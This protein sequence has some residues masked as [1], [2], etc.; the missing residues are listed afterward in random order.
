LFNPETYTPEELVS[1]RETIRQVGLGILQL[2]A[3]ITPHITEMLYQTFYVHRDNAPSSIHTTSLQNIAT[4]ID[5]KA[6]TLTDAIV[7]TAIEVRRLK[8]DHNLP[9]GK[10]LSL[11]TVYSEDAT[12]RSG[13]ETQSRLL[14]G[15]SRAQKVVISKTAVAQSALLQK[16]DALSVTIRV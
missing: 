12:L 5:T 1:T 3:P 7:A 11:L 9:L 16:D 15:V 10:P 13:L 4:E 2:F 14:A 8:S 6:I